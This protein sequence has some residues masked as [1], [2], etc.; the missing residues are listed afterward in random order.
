MKQN[1]FVE[2]GVGNRST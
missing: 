1:A 2:K